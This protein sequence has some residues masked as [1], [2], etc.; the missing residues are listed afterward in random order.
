MTAPRSF[1]LLS[2]LPG[3]GAARLLAQPR[4]RFVHARHSARLGPLYRNLQKRQRTI[5]LFSQPF[6]KLFLRI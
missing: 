4:Q 3:M 2:S 5:L 1:G 6:V